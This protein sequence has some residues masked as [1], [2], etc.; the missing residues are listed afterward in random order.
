MPHTIARPGGLGDGP[1]GK[2]GIRVAQGEPPTASQIQ[3]ADVATVRVQALG[4]PDAYGKTFEIVGG[5]RSANV[6]WARSFASS[7]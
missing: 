3:R 1:C 2:V 5:E 7:A 4:S 6:D